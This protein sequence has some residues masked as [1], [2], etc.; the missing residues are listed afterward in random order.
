MTFILM[1]VVITFQTICVSNISILA[2]QQGEGYMQLCNF[3]VSS[4][5]FH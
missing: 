3:Q 2:I 1:P 4:L 5:I